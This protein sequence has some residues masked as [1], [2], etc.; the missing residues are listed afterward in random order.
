MPK[1]NLMLTRTLILEFNEEQRTVFCVFSG[2]G[3]NKLR[4][5]LN[6]TEEDRQTYAS[7]LSA[8][9]EGM[10]EENGIN[11]MLHNTAL[12]GEDYEE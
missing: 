4:K 6:E 1:I 5:H 7:S 10:D 3:V 2:D 12:D 9:D 8:Y 11:G